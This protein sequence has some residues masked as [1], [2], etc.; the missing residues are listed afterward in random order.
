ETTIIT[1]CWAA[2]N[3]LSEYPEFNHLTVNHSLNF[4]NPNDSSIHTQTIESCWGH[5]KRT[6]KNQND[7]TNISLEGYLYEIAF[8]REF[9]KFSCFNNFLLL[10][11]HRLPNTVE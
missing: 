7:T 1:D 8:K 9:Q 5:A 10:L 6:L 11:K 3:R 4:L 2:Y